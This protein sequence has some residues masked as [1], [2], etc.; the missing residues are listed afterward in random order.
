MTAGREK[1]RKELPG[2]RISQAAKNAGVSRQTVEYYILVGLV[3]P[4]RGK[5]GRARFFDDKLV[6]RIKLIKE[7]NATGY[8]LLDIREL[9]LKGK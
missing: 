7:L 2:L 9:F 6:R 3:K 4:I 8:T 5:D 1:N